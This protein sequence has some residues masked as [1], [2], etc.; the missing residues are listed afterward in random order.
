[1]F[2]VD[3]TMDGNTL[4]DKTASF[5]YIM[6]IIWIMH[7]LQF[8]MNTMIEVEVEDEK[9]KVEGEKSEA[10]LNERKN[11]W[12]YRP[13]QRRFYDDRWWVW[14]LQAISYIVVVT[15]YFTTDG[16]EIAY[17]IYIPVDFVLF[18][19]MAAFYF[20]ARQADKEEK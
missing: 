12:D 10:L 2:K 11:Q 4:V 18:V 7:I 19:G 20:Q 9:T 14:I 6:M 8:L 17:A 15:L 16:F 13:V 5:R 3:H 1:M